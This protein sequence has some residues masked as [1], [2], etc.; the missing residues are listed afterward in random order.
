MRKGTPRT[1]DGGG[2]LLVSIPGRDT[3]NAHD[4]AEKPVQLGIKGL[5]GQKAE[6]GQHVL[7]SVPYDILVRAKGETHGRAVSN[8]AR[9]SPC[10][11]LTE[12][13]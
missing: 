13:K 7:A 12:G 10:V 4:S 8:A 3:A 9:G 1:R 5:D 2:H 6:L 11:A